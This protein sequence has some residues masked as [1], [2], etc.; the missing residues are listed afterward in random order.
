M[1]IV[2]MLMMFLTATMVLR[3]R[4]A[5]LKNLEKDWVEPSTVLLIGVNV[6]VAVLLLWEI[7][8]LVMK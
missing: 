2:I 8:K 6:I 3:G 7:G 5:V 1:D 4:L